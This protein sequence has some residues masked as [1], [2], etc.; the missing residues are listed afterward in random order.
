M[1]S[2][3]FAELDKNLR[4]APVQVSSQVQAQIQAQIRDTRKGRIV[5]LLPLLCLIHCVGTAILASLMPAAALL[6][7][8]EWLEGLLSLFSVLLIGTLVLRGRSLAD[9]LSILF[10]VTVLL[11]GVGWIGHFSWLRHGSLLLL[12]GVQLLW[13]RQRR[14]QHRHLHAAAPH[15]ASAGHSHLSCTCSEHRSK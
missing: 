10:G 15:G 12:V 14:L 1:T 13:L 3:V 6:L 8:N 7:H 2:Q 11:G 4:P 9:G 5:G